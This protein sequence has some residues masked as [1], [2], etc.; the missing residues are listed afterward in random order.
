MK[1]RAPFFKEIDKLLDAIDADSGVNGARLEPYFHGERRYAEIDGVRVQWVNHKSE[2]RAHQ[3]DL[4]FVVQDKT[5]AQAEEDIRKLLAKYKKEN[6]IA[7]RSKED[8]AK[9]KAMRLAWQLDPNLAD[10]LAQ[11]HVDSAEIIDNLK[12]YGVTAKTLD[13]LKLKEVAPGQ[14]AYIWEGRSKHYKALGADHLFMGVSD[15][16]GTRK[17]IVSLWADPKN[18]SLKASKVRAQESIVGNG[19]SEEPDARKGGANGV[20]MRIVT[21]DDKG[22]TK[23]IYKN[24]YKGDNYRIIYDPKILERTDWYAYHDDNYGST[25]PDKWNKRPS[26]DDF[27]KGEKNNYNCNN[28]IMFRGRVGVENAIGISCETTDMQQ[29]LIDEFHRQDVY[30]INGKRVEDFIRVETK[31]RRRTK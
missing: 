6:I 3:G 23:F 22:K 20:F 17:L 11:K 7:P 18:Q 27:I 9:Y 16:A 29:S 25:G 24:A 13:E 5:N 15:N 31:A 8:I 30:N 1:A 28:E 19:A 14:T 10:S 21:K 2:Y 4:E 12:P 26:V